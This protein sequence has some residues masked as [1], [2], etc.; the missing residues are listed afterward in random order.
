MKGRNS[1]GKV[2]LEDMKRF[3]V[4]K[5]FG[6][7]YVISHIKSFWCLLKERSKILSVDFQDISAGGFVPGFSVH[8]FS[9]TFM[10]LLCKEREQPRGGEKPSTQCPLKENGRATQQKMK[11]ETLGSSTRDPGTLKETSGLTAADW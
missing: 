4:Y 3:K 8:L 9:S 6:S 5:I 11:A 1:N 10:L 2:L 7:V